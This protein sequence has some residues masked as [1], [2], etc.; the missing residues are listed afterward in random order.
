[1]RIL[2]L[3]LMEIFMEI[4]MGILIGILM[5]TVMGITI[6]IMM[7]IVMDFETENYH[8]NLNGLSKIQL[9]MIG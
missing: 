2:A 9:I 7:R 3:N 1:M 8:D 4:F 5:G 6:G